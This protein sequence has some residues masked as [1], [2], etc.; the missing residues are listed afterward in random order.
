MNFVFRLLSQS[1]EI[2]SKK[3]VVY[4]YTSVSIVSSVLTDVKCLSPIYTE[5][6]I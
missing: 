1:N 6:L 4:P 3:I 5:L 2:E